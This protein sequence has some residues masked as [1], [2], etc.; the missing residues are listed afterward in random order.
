M[1][2][3]IGILPVMLAL[4]CIGILPVTA[5]L[6]Q[7]DPQ[8][9]EFVEVV[10][11][12]V[13]VRALRKGKPVSGLKEFDFTLFENGKQQKIT[14]FMEIKRKIG[15]GQEETGAGKKAVE[16][17]GKP[18]KRRVFFL[19]FRI[20]EPSPQYN[21]ALD[22]FFEH[23]YRDGDYVL[24]IVD[25][26]AFKVTRR[27]QLAET[28]QNVK[29]KLDEVARRAKSEKD[30]LIKEL[31]KLFRDFQADFRQ[32][33]MRKQPQRPLVDRLISRY[34]AAWDQYRF[35]YA[36]IDV[37][38]IKAL[39][40][41]LKTVELEKWGIVF[42]QHDTFPLLNPES[43]FAE[44]EDSSKYIFEL[45]KAFTAFDREMQQ[46]IGSLEFLKDV[47][48]A[49]ID[50]NT[51]F[52]LL[53]SGP[54]SAGQLQSV[55]LK[56]A[57][58]YSDWKET[59]RNISKSTG[60][61]ILDGNVLKDSLG[62]AIN[63]EDIYYR[64][65]FAPQ[66]YDNTT[67]KIEVKL[68]KKGPELYY[69]QRLLLHRSE[70]IKISDFSFE[71]PTLKFVL[72]RYRMF[73]DGTG[74]TGD[75]EIRLTAVDTGGEMSTFK[76]DLAPDKEKVLV[77]LKL[78][79]PVGGDYTMVVEALDRQTGE[80]AVYSRRINVPKI[81]KP[82]DLE[83][84]LVKTV[85]KKDPGI[86]SRKNKLKSIL[87][88]SADYC[89]KL[90]KT[91]FYFTCR[92]EITDRLTRKG[93]TERDKLFAYDYQI[94]MHENGKMDERRELIGTSGQGKENK[95]K[96]QREKEKRE[97]EARSLLITNFY[98]RYSFLLPITL[99]SRENREKYRFQ[100]LSRE[101]IEDCDTYKISVDPKDKGTGAVNHGLVWLDVGDGSVVK[102][103][104]NPRSLRGIDRLRSR[105]GRKGTRLK[106]T[107]VH[108]YDVIKKGI[109][110]PSRTEISRLFLAT[111][112]E[113][114]QSTRTEHAL[115][116]FSYKNYRF[117]NVNVAVVESS[118]N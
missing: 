20:A 12:E 24:M 49:F 61:E 37:E 65:T 6:R 75:I 30:I 82:K 81:L 3:M 40:A 85:H 27:L 70:S 80:S 77:S 17:P 29:T 15:E 97:S 21:D 93:E 45:R 31:D 19:Y 32:N 25:N 91:T 23:V 64:L 72:D 112:P 58:I 73:Y 117:F 33:E 113:D 8:V 16:G 67:R 110:F 28:V 76:R 36:G 74:P 53:L 14:S 71:L 48:Q 89:E 47:R 96:K 114:P 57:R 46:P 86:I 43:I 51:T 50:A 39:A 83:G 101:K 13:I 44:D 87:E 5:T 54:R 55:Y 104:L 9:Q 7:E 41:S 92:E 60:G 59:F 116:V 10:N 63:K 62:L 100:L 66:S 38:K 42:Y 78:D 2:R 111:Q 22:Y 102:I 109:R 90:K 84:I 69:N 1:K 115:T 94:I 108:W 106:L 68:D 4:L 26:Q 35:K 18:A 118:M 79:F 56:T 98:S 105:A 11:V 88:K 103:E 95:K 107:D 34:R 99:L 52:H